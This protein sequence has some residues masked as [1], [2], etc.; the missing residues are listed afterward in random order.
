MGIPE[1]GLEEASYND[2][3][4]EEEDRWFFEHLF[5]HYDHGSEEPNGIQ[6]QQLSTVYH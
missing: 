5:Q 3:K 4:Q 1:E 2:E 6:V